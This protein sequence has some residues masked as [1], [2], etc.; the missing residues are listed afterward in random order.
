MCL[1]RYAVNGVPALRCKLR[2]D[3]ALCGISKHSCDAILQMGDAKAMLALLRDG[4]SPLL[5]ASYSWGVRRAEVMAVS[6]SSALLE[7]DLHWLTRAGTALN[8]D[9]PWL[10]GVAGEDGLVGF[11]EECGLEPSCE[12]SSN[13]CVQASSPSAV[14]ELENV[15]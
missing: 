4:F 11:R 14:H 1:G 12:G 10:L 7:G 9:N 2:G 8:P 5:I 13:L 15:G 3:P 6:T